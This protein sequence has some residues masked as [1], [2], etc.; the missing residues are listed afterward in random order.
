MQELLDPSPST[1]SGVG[2]AGQTN[3]QG[4]VIHNHQ[5]AKIDLNYT[6]R[7]RTHSFY[8]AHARDHQISSVIGTTAVNWIDLGSDLCLTLSAL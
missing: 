3:D 7:A 1:I 2:L 8:D 6:L 5:H 4:A